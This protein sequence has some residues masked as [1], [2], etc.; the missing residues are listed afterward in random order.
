MEGTPTAAGWWA[1]WPP[2]LPVVVPHFGRVIHMDERTLTV[3]QR[4]ER[5]LAQLGSALDRMERKLDCEALERKLR[6]EA[7]VVDGKAGG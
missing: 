5:T 6:K 7:A 4:L 1:S 2:A 3:E